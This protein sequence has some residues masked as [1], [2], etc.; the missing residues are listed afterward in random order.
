MPQRHLDLLA[1]A[2]RARPATVA[3]L[4]ELSLGD[5]M[6]VAVQVD[7]LVEDG[8]L[9]LHGDALGYEPPAEPVAAPVA[10][11]S[12]ALGD[13]LVAGLAELSALVGQLPALARDWE[14]GGANNHGLLEV[15]VF[16]G[17]SAVTDLWH[18]V[19]ER[20]P[21]RRT[22]VVL[23]DASRLYVADPAMQS[24]WHD[25]ISQ[26]GHR[27]RVIGNVTEV[28]R[29][30]AA[31]R[32]SEELA[33]GVDIRIR[34]ELPGWFWVAD[35]DVVAL[36]LR[37]GENWP[38]SAIAVRSPAIAGLAQWVFDQLW[39]TAVPVREGATSWEP[40]LQLMANGATVESASHALG[41][42][43]RT[44]RRRIADAMEHYRAPSLFALG[45]AW[46][47]DRRP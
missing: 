22:D 34:A 14:I 42:S 17:W 11:R 47:R 8:F 2:L 28:G 46:N 30:E 6:T 1:T 20:R 36:P 25:M 12:V 24:T 4:A 21:L 9:T 38:T 45:A 31:Q 23:P 32:I 26:P 33:G 16:H 7:E 37:W 44:G 41:I 19:I 43:D 15:E 39:A 27:A 29:P 40:L 13:E 35:G 5:P 18:Q 3:A 10:R